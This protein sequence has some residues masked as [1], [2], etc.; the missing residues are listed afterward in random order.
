VFTSDWAGAD[1]ACAATYG[2]QLCSYEQLHRACAVGG[3]ALTKNTWL[4]EISDDNELGFY[5]GSTTCSSFVTTYGE[6]TSGDPTQPA[7]YCC[8]E[9]MTY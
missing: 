8:I 2:G 6:M 5:V 1:T 9:W 3:Y 4:A 7:A